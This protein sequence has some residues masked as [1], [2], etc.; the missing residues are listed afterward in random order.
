MTTAREIF[1]VN[2]WRSWRILRNDDE[3]GGL[4]ERD[5]RDSKGGSD[6]SESSDMFSAVSPSFS[7]CRIISHHKIYYQGILAD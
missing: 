7:L 3:S 2:A 5:W 1:V 6:R 4:R